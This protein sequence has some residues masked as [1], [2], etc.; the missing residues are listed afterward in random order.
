MTVIK[1][2][3]SGTASW[4]PIVSGV[5]GPT[6]PTGPNGPNPGLQLIK[7]QTIGS[8][9]SSV[10]VT[11]AFSS[12]YDNYQIT[13]AGG[14]TNGG[15]Y[16]LNMRLGSTTTGYHYYGQYSNFANTFTN[17]INSAGGSEWGAVGITTTNNLMAN[18]FVSSPFLTKATFFHCDYIY[19]N[20]SGGRANM[21]GYLNDSNSYTAFTLFINT[22]SMTGGTI[23]VYGYRNS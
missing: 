18:I 11:D 8:G 2:Y 10:T 16:G 1:E 15:D 6:G 13:V 17:A 20:P 5:Q 19:N 9:V 14:A 21:A 3:N 23:R 12:T 4:Q 22:S 7:T